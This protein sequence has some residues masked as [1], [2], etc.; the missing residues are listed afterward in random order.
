MKTRNFV[1]EQYLSSYIQMYVLT[2]RRAHKN[3]HDIINNV[4]TKIIPIYVYICK[5]QIDV[6]SL[7]DVQ[8]SNWRPILKYMVVFHFLQI[9]VQ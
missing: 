8:I 4:H 1:L 6:Q 2:A 9:D 7:I 3:G 5:T